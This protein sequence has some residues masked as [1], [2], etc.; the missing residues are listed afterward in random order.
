MRLHVDLDIRTDWEDGEQA[1]LDA[2]KRCLEQAAV[3]EGIEEAEVSVSIVDDPVI[4]QL[5]RDFRGVD[6][7][8]D[9]LSFPQ[10][11][12]DEEPMLVSGE[13]L[14][15][16]DVVISLRRARE[17][18]QTYGHSL[19]REIAFLAVHG[20][21]HLLGYDHQQE[22]EEAEMFS[23]QEAILNQAGLRR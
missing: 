20:F 14:P 17:Q 5:N 3:S 7:P 9:V 4:H 6:S 18:A 16:G 23:R 22:A 2:V 21:L 11:E 13:R 1:A 8:T 10:W 12:P 19:E 15:L